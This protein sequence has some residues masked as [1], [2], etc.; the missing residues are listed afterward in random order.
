[1]EDSSPSLC[2][3]TRW[4]K[5]VWYHRIEK[6]GCF[7]VNKA[8]SR[9]GNVQHFFLIPVPHISK[10]LMFQDTHSIQS[11]RTGFLHVT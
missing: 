4:Q 10:Y 6:K 1:M 8:W 7:Y 3:T 11:Y 2:K 5:H 9:A